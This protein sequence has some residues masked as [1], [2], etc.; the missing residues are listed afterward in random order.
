M[1]MISFIYWSEN[2][3]EACS[4]KFSLSSLTFSNKF[5]NYCKI[6]LKQLV[7]MNSINNEAPK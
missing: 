1:L 2:F 4:N 5:A 6:T 7:L 3:S